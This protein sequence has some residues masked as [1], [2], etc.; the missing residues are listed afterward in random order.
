MNG[1]RNLINIGPTLKSL[2]EERGLTIR[3]LASLA[4][5]PYPYL[6]NIENNKA[7]PTLDILD[8]ICYSLNVKISELFLK[9]DLEK[10]VSKE[11][12]KLYKDF[13]PLIRKINNIAQK[14]YGDDNENNDDD[15]DDFNGK[16]NKISPIAGGGVTVPKHSQALK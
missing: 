10:H 4:E 11:K 7:N 2:R 9:N 14:L 12:R 13:K 16:D 1:E 3:E 15:N 8:R 5:V 6:S